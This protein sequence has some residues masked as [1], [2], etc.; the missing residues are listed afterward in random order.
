MPRTLHTYTVTPDLPE[1]LAALR[2]LAYNLRWS[3]DHSTTQLFREVDPANWETSGHNPAKLLGL[4]SRK[5]LDDLT[6][7]QDFLGQLDAVHAEFQRY[8]NAETWWTRHHGDRFPADFRIGYFSAEFG[9]TESLPI[10]S[11]GLGVLAGD[12]LKSASDLGLPLVG[13][14]FLYQKGYFRQALNADGWQIENYP[15]T[16]FYSLPILP[17]YQNGNREGGPVKVQ[18]RFPG[19]MVTAQVW[20][21]QVGRVSLFLLDTNLPENTEADRFIAGN[22]YGGDNETRIQQE[23][24]LGIGGIHALAAMGVRPTV[25]HMNE[26]HSAFL[27]LERVRR[28]VH[29][30]GLTFAEAVEAAAAGN[31]FTTHTPVPAGFDKFPPDLMYRYFESYLNDV[32]IPFE[33]LMARGRENRNNPSE[34]LN[35]AILAGRNA[36]YIN[37]VSKLHGEVSRKMVEPVYP[38]IPLDE[39]P[40][41]SVTNGI[42]TRTFLS[43]EMTEL[44][45]SYLGSPTSDNLA[46]PDYW[47]GVK[48]VPDFEL[49]TVRER[50]RHRLVEWARQYQVKRL[51][52]RGAAEREVAE[53]L[54]I[55]DPGILTIGFARR[56]ATYKRGDLLLRDVD[57]LKRMLNH[58]TRPVQFVFA[59]KAHP[60]DEEGKRLIQHIVHF[61][62]DPEI[63]RRIVF[64]EDY[65]M[66]MAR[67]LVQGVD[68]WLNNPRRPMEASGTSGM[69]VVANGG[70]NFSIL[71]GWWAE[72]YEPGV[73]WEIGRGEEYD[74]YGY[75]DHVE[76]HDVYDTLER[77]IIPLF[78]ERNQDGLPTGWIAKIKTSMMRLAPV[79]NTTRMVREYAETYYVPAAERARLLAENDFART[80]ALVQWKRRVQSSWHE[81]R[82]ESVRAETEHL[83]AGDRVPVHARVHLGASLNPED[84]AVQLY[85][86]RIDAD[87]NL[88]A[89]TAVPMTL[90][91]SV[92]GGVHLYS[93][94]LPSEISG[95]HGFT[96]RVLPANADAVLPQELPLITWE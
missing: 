62:R 7:D 14:G 91:N 92:G 6:A 23:I 95:Q 22:L 38:G 34:P 28:L 63:R 37:G 57:R 16:D 20:K 67:Y 54:E 12:H 41:G 53:A 18:V 9:I 29:E 83:R 90:D 49:W 88:N 48:D 76:A 94:F 60:R 44:L 65:D 72:A 45:D 50:R 33:D 47:A 1:R 74:D 82:I 93:G 77:E 2:E 80:K 25:C 32:H 27:A 46:Q 73:G 36:R 31:L 5:R 30:R 4:V 89:A 24:V 3:W 13:V 58:P 42:H 21:A 85:T 52:R 39:V 64:L 40:V 55:L 10:Y 70:L 35:M 11:G 56:F 96:V 66:A 87:R 17:T 78:Y 26:G 68:V 79:Y 75:Q 15:T 19:R 86:G 71:D 61:S 81:I 59:G 43:S 84:V 8:L 69:K 51:E